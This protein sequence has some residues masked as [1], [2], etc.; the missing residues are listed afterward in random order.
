MLAIFTESFKFSAQLR[1]FAGVLL[2]TF[3]C[4]PLG[5]SAQTAPNNYWRGQS[6]YQ[7]FTDRFL[8]WRLKQQ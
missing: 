1:L 4:C 6:I 7:I 8:R 3:C 5:I 2:G